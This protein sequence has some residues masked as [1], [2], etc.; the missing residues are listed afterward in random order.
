MKK[1]ADLGCSLLENGPDYQND[2]DKVFLFAGVPGTITQKVD[3]HFWLTNAQ[4]NNFLCKFQFYNDKEQKVKNC[5]IYW[6][7]RHFSERDLKFT[8]LDN[9]YTV[10][11][12]EFSNTI[13]QHYDYKCYSFNFDIHH[14][15]KNQL[16]LFDK[17]VD[18]C[19]AN[20]TDYHQV[21]NDR[22]QRIGYAPPDVNRFMVTYYWQ[23]KPKHETVIANRVLYM[24]MT[25]EEKAR[26]TFVQHSTPGRVSVTPKVSVFASPQNIRGRNSILKSKV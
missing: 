10:G 2:T 5:S 3:Y 18:E 25:A 11:L 13:Y 6:P 14:Q 1:L 21:I 12:G 23:L 22:W 7:Y 16:L 20:N 4:I 9:N 8:L 15:T 19:I 26:L 24:N 17:V